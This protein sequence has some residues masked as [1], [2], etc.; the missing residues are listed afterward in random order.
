MN[1]HKLNT[2]K[3]RPPTDSD[4]SESHFDPLDFNMNWG[5]TRKHLIKLAAWAEKHKTVIILRQSEFDTLDKIATGK[6]K[7]KSVDVKDKSSNWGPQKG[8]VT[9]DPAFSK[10]ALKE[11]KP[12]KPDKK[13]ADENLD[14]LK[15]AE[16]K[17]KTLKGPNGYS[18]GIGAVQVYVLGKEACSNKNY[19][20]DQN[21]ELD[22]IWPGL[23]WKFDCKCSGD[24]KKDDNQEC[25][26]FWIDK[27]NPDEEVPLM[28]WS[29]DK[30]AVTG[31]YDLWMVA[32]HYKWNGSKVGHT[33]RMTM[34]AVLGGI[35][36]MPTFTDQL[37]SPLSKRN[38]NNAMGRPWNESGWSVFNHGAE[39]QNFYFVQDLDPRLTV[40]VPK[41]LEDDASK[42]FDKDDQ[43]STR[44]KGC[45]EELMPIYRR[46]Q[47]YNVNVKDDDG[48]A[49]AKFINMIRMCGFMAPTNLRYEDEEKDK[50]KEFKKNMKKASEGLRCDAG[51]RK[52]YEEAN[53]YF[54][55]ITDCVEKSKDMYNYY[56]VSEECPAKNF[57]KEFEKM[58]ETIDA[59]EFDKL[60][61]SKKLDKIK[62]D[63]ATRAQNELA[64]QI[65]TEYKKVN[66]DSD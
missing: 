29:Y 56:K 30:A 7:T 34:S 13:Y 41:L 55:V 64:A 15:K 10:L 1:E 26:V 50:F 52:I 3:C 53:D 49:L 63:S 17:D 6:Y 45:Q 14:K 40:I 28:A 19:Q 23:S 12:D 46:G 4:F 18:T 25:K 54:N 36:T 43:G 2:S 31:D 27:Q 65:E 22:K 38:L 32:P 59:Q 21:K 5:I 47:V 61:C 35:A 58:E 66:P 62:T 8:L 51:V 24:P 16:E 39:M 20:V 9:L 48:L 57:K 33:M 11:D 44:F 42:H 37:V 60:Y